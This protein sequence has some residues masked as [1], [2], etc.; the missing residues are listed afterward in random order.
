MKKVFLIII[1]LLL[2]GCN[3]DL[4]VSKNLYYM[5]TVI[6]IKIYNTSEKKANDAIN[7]I[8]QLYKKYDSIASY[9]NT[10]SELY[11][12]NNKQL[13][14][15]S[16][17]LKNLILLGVDWYYKSNGLLNINIGGLSSRWKVFRE[18]QDNMPTIEELNQIDININNIDTN[19][20]ISSNT[21]IDLGSITKGYVTEIAADYLEN[22]GI[23]YYIINAGGNVKLGKSNKDG[24]IV[25]IKS[26]I[27]NSNFMK[28][29]IENK[30]VVTSGGY[31]R[32]YEV[33]GVMYHHIID[34]NTRF[35]ANYMK[36]VTVI[37]S[38][39]GVCDALSTILFLM[40]IDSGKEFIKDYDVDVIWFTLDN[41]IITSEGFNYE[42]K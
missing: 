24:Y 17:E 4:Y 21:N 32:F 3:K 6:N 14:E 12:L 23:N 27:D 36:S 9:Y 18:T 25:G 1:C 34:P 33:D 15:I 5:D 7:Y 13:T 38:D 30:S 39:S 8:E 41:E 22:I 40:D 42:Q 29:S 26:P 28:L 19:D 10:D 37:G 35:P 20:I 11:K 2:T 31:E 16:D